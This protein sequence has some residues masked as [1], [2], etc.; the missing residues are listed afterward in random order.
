LIAAVFL[1]LPSKTS[2]G[3]IWKLLSM[4]DQRDISASYIPENNCGGRLKLVLADDDPAAMLIRN[5]SML[6][7]TAACPV[8]YTVNR[9][10]TPDCVK[11]L[12]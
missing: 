6:Y 3:L 12:V 7:R 1:R 10:I 11:G 8:G 9:K 4:S 2:P 5:P